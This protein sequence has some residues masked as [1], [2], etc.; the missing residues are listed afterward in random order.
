[1]II[2]FAL[3]LSLSVHFRWLRV[4]A[5]AKPYQHPLWS[6]FFAASKRTLVVP[7]DSGLVIWEGLEKK[8]LS[9]A[10]FL[11]GDFRTSSAANREQEIAEDLSQRRYTSIVDLEAVQTLTKIATS[12]NGDLEARYARDLRM[13]DLKQYNVILLGAAEAN[14]WVELYAPMMRFR[15]FK[16]EST[17]RFSIENVAPRNGEPPS[18]SFNTNTAYAVVAYLP[19]FKGDGNALLIGGTSM[20]GTESALD[21]ISDDSQLL[22][23]LNGLKRTDGN[24]P[25]FEVVLG[26]HFVNNS[27]VR[28]KVLAWRSLD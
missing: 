17:G 24:I 20:T 25:H 15:L 11:K 3:L 12:R 5:T 9:L 8:N 13:E 18:W 19:G 22:P 1:M 14:P 16:D 2:V 27:A 10:E 4:G 26:T 21:F 6:N 28:S 7:G 23:F